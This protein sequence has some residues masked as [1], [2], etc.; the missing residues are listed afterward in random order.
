MEKPK[1]IKAI[2]QLEENHP[3][4]QKS[5]EILIPLSSISI[6]VKTMYG[7]TPVLKSE[8]K[9]NSEFPIKSIKVFISEEEFEI[10]SSK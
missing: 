7:Y 2:A 6:L 9:S 1:F 4:Q 8:I 10:I 3:S 5:V